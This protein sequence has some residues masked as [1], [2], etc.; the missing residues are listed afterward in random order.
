M[1]DDVSVPADLQPVYERRTRRPGVVGEK[2]RRPYQRRLSRRKL[3]KLMRAIR[4]R[5]RRQLGN[6]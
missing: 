1:S 4:A 2:R 5:R 6:I 3:N